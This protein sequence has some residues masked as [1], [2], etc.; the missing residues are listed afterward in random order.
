[1]LRHPPP[2]PDQNP[3]VQTR[4]LAD[5]PEGA[6]CEVVALDDSCTG[7]L[8]QRLL[9]LGLTPGARVIVASE[10]AFGDPRAYRI[11]GALMAL[12]REQAQQVLV[13]L[14]EMNAQGPNHA[15]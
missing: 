7:Y 8:R 3:E 11:R 12:R 14:L 1:M 4:T 13:R 5:L 9:D 6:A 15:S 10:N 2:L